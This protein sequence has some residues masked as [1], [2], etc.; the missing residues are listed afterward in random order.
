MNRRQKP[1]S[2]FFGKWPGTSEEMQMIKRTLAADRKHFKT[3][4]A[5]F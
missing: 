1:L 5:V 4:A 2:D 3:K